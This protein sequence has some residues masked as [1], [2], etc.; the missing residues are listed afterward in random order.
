MRD[1][2][3]GKDIVRNATNGTTICSKPYFAQTM[4]SNEAYGESAVVVTVQN[5]IRLIPMY[6]FIS[7][8][9]KTMKVWSGSASWMKI[10]L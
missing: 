2:G 8:N 6:T 1:F 9:R 7:T 5:A 10:L 4:L 3:S